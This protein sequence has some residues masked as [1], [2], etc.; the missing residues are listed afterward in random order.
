MCLAYEPECMQAPCWSSE[1]LQKVQCRF[2]ELY[3]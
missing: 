1:R 2:P 3:L